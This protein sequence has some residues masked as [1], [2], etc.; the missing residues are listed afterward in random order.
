VTVQPPTNPR[1]RAAIEY[2]SPT[3]LRDRYY[4][5]RPAAGRD[6]HGNSAGSQT[7][8]P[9][10]KDLDTASF[11]AASSAATTLADIGDKATKVEPPG[12]GDPWRYLTGVPPSPLAKEPD[13]GSGPHSWSTIEQ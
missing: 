4:A 5:V 1:A 8:L 11:I 3:G 7:A 6:G 9:G 13:H 12:E 2:P 10:V